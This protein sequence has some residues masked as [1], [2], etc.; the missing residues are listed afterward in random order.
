LRLDTITACAF[1]LIPALLISFLPGAW[2]KVGSTLTSVFLL[3]LFVLAVYMENA[4][5]PF[6]AEYDVRPNVIFINYLK[7]PKEVLNT[8][9]SVYKLELLLAGLMMAAF[10]WWFY[11]RIKPA[12]LDVYSVA[13]WKRAI[14]F[15]P[16]FIIIFAGLRSSFGHRP[17]NP[18]DAVF[19]NNRLLNELAKN[20]IHNVVYAAY[21]RA[22]HDGTADKYGSMKIDEALLRVGKRLNIET[23]GET[24]FMREV[25]SH[26][27]SD[28]KK[29]LVIFLQESIGAQFVAA[30]GGE[31]GITPR[32]NALSEE[33][34]LFTRLYS[35]GTRSIRGISGTVAGFLST[36]GQG[37]V[38]RNQSQS[39]FFTVASLLKPH[40][41]RSSFFYGGESRFDNMK[42]WFFGNGFDEIYDEPTFTEAAFHGTWGV[43]D[44][45]LVVKANQL[46]SEWN[47][48]GEP[49]VSVMF[50]TT[51]HSPFEFPEGR[52]ELL[53]GV[54]ANSDKNAIKFADYAIGKFIDL[55]KENGYYDDTVI[56]VIAD[57]NVRVYGDDIIPV[58][59][60]RVP[61]LI[62]GGGVTPARID[63]LVT[64]PDALATALDLLGLDLAYPILGNSIF[65]DRQTGV[66]LLQFHELYGL[67]YEDEIAIIQP[68]KPAET[69]RV[70]AEDHLEP[71]AHNTA[72]EK[73]ALAF[74]VVLDYLYR[75]RLYTTVP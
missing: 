56:M 10:G 73:D 12:I 25:A 64:Q 30:I 61:A 28:N 27:S 16:I 72:L 13:W 52:I 46:F 50:T 48:A 59:T 54:P 43:S 39:G 71:A 75:N 53:P 6:I 69:Y 60:F 23:T 55:A 18:S 17:A 7:Y 3:L 41:Y 62:L 42:S 22:A 49:F 24:P 33:G 4:T 21:S 40:G 66:S 15:V 74:V 34:L 11:R 63:K 2:A 51:N 37:V 36:P 38:K 26:F 35:N 19:S 70:T 58:D 68:D 65:S 57:H 1:L 47:N 9:W 14:V 5:L 44:E 32:L 20:T 45:D 67:R 8:I 31:P 29:N